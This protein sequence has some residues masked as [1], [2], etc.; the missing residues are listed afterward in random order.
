M[1]FSLTSPAPEK[2]DPT[3]KNR[4]WGF[5]GE[6]QQSHRENRA[7]SLQPRQGDPSSLTKTVSGRTYWPSRDP[8]G[9]RGG[10]NLYGMVGNN[11]V[12]AIDLLGLEMWPADGGEITSSESSQ[13][14]PGMAIKGESTFTPAYIDT[15]VGNI[16][17]G[18]KDSKL[19]VSQITL[20]YATSAWKS[21]S[22]PYDVQVVVRLGS[23]QCA[24]QTL[25]VSTFRRMV[26]RR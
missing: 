10:F 19:I 24:C 25:T 11:S 26:S 14:G 9:E 16:N 5:F 8:I 4:V 12:G 15:V 7:Q 13:I 17:S 23:G 6:T 22:S 2:S 20:H 18:V 3:A 21:Y 1:G